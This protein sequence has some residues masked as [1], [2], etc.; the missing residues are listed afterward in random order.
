MVALGDM[1][2]SSSAEVSTT[3]GFL[4][5]SGSNEN[6]PSVFLIKGHCHTC[7]LWNF[8]KFSEFYVS[9][10]KLMIILIVKMQRF[11]HKCRKFT[12]TFKHF[13]FSRISLFEKMVKKPCDKE[14]LDS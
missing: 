2:R 11:E 1:K 3:A 12:R 7:F 6:S 10:K 9:S 5:N 8:T 4:Q 14:R 13:N